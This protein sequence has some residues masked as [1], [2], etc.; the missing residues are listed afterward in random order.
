LCSLVLS[1]VSAIDGVK[2]V[3]LIDILE[4]QTVAIL[5]VAVQNVAVYTFKPSKGR[6]AY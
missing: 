4:Q 5:N 6:Q 2:I 1:F 3:L